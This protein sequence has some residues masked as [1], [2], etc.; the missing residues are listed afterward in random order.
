[1]AVYAKTSVPPRARTLPGRYYTSADVHQKER[2]RIF[3]R[4]WLCVGREE[5]IRN[6]GD[7]FLAESAGESIIV[8]RGTDGQARAFFNVC[9]HR[10]TRMCEVPSGTFAGAIMCPYHAWTY[11]L[12]GK[13]TAARNM[14]DL[15]DFDKADYPLRTVALANWE[16]FLFIN[17]TREADTFDQDFSSLLGRFAQWRIGETRIARS[18]TYELSC[19]WKLVFQNYSECYHCPLIHPALDRL[20]AS[21]SGRND[22]MRG[23]FLG[24]YM[25]LRD[26]GTSMTVSGHTDR[27]PLG[28]VAGDE[29]DRVYF[30]TIFPSM[31]L[32]LHPDYIMAHR[33]YPLAVNRTKVVCEWLF[34]ADTM[35]KPGFDPSDA[36]EFWDMTNRQDWHVC[37]LSQ[38]GIESVAYAP[39]PYSNQ[40]GLLY[41]FDQH[42]LAAL[43][44]PLD[45]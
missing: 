9:R 31:L 28:E 32:S 12:D 3:T 30:Y 14:Q 42:Y 37:E 41:E 18:I 33:V 22:L 43:G 23:P 29:L 10:G 11:A 39:G 26:P 5:Q 15:E 40:E 1:M 21:T 45:A 36:V 34:D 7:Y 17:L 24:G 19:N 6:K 27:P 25:T 20:T 44:P 13:L 38:A 2:E 4:R 16:G 8:V 35:A